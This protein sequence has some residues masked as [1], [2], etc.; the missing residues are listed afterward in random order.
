MKFKLQNCHYWI[1]LFWSLVAL[2]AATAANQDDYDVYY[3]HLDITIDPIA[4]T[5]NG[6]VT[7]CATSLVDNLAL[8][9]L[10]LYDNMKVTAVTGNVVGFSHHDH[11]LVLQLDR[12]YQRQQSLAVTV[13]YSGHP[14][15]GTR[16][17]PM[18]FDRS[19]GVVTISSESCPFYA[20]C[21]WPCKDRPDD[22]PDSMDVKITVPATLTAASNGW[23]VEIIDNKNG[24]KTHHWQIRNPIATYLVAFTVTN[25]RVMTDRYIGA[26]GD[27]LPIRHFVYPEHYN[28]ALVD[29]DNVNTMLQVM[30]SYY[31]KYPYYN[32]KYGIAEYIGYWGGMEYQSLTTVQPY[33]ITGDHT[34]DAVYVHE[35]AHQWWGDCITP[36]DFHHT[37]ISEGFATF[38]EALYFGHLEGPARYHQYMN[39]NNN[40]LETKGILY[41]HNVTNP[42]SVYAQIV[43]NKGAWVIHML[44]HV[45][46]EDKFWAGLRAYRSEFEYKSATTE[47]LQHVF[48][49]VVGDSLGW[50]FRQWIYQ[51]NYP[52]YAF[53][54]RQEQL[55]EHQYRLIAFIDQIQPDAPLFTMPL[56]FTLRTVAKESTF[57]EIVRDSTTTFEWMLPEPATDLQ[58]DKDGWVLKKIVQITTPQPEYVSH[59]LLDATGHGLEMAEPGA[60]VQLLLQIRNRGLLAKQI[61]AELLTKDADIQ[62]RSSRIEFGPLDHG[63]MSSP[64]PPPPPLSFSVSPTAAAHLA[65]FQVRFTANSGYQAIDS[66]LVK[67]GN[68]N[69]LLVDDDHGASYEQYFYQ[70]LTLAR[71]YF[72]RWDTESQGC[73]TA[74]GVLQRYQ[75]VIWF[76]G[77]DRS[78]SLTAEEQQAI[79][80]YLAGGGRLLLTGQDIGVDLMGDGSAQDSAFYQQVLHADF[81]S[82]T[83]AT[84]MMMGISGDPIAGG[85]FVY[86][87]AR[88]GGARNQ[89]SP[90][91]IAPRDGAALILKYL[92]QMSGAGIR[93]EDPATGAR[94][95]YLAFGME[96]ISGPHSDTAKKL[97]DRILSWLAGPTVVYSHPLPAVPQEY[98]L[99]QNFP[100]PFNAV[101]RI[102]Y[103]LPQTDRVTV[104]IYNLSGQKLKT[105]VN[106][107]QVAGVY[108]LLWDGTDDRNMPVATGIYIC[109]LTGR[110][111]AYSKKIALIK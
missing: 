13:H 60:T 33:L 76:T 49:K 10:D 8:I 94:L 54:Y 34:Y 37:W 84:T 42:D 89:L 90:S 11:L 1:I 111:V 80:A 91:A 50:F 17:N 51:P 2:P 81:I 4:E 82:D 29:F 19:R 61:Q 86:I 9:T 38:S 68:P 63:Q 58:I 104:N 98:E 75:Q 93:Y 32:E 55:A 3:Y 102:K 99:W 43:Y 101:T 26:I 74:A 23:L 83:V 35:L 39:E 20:R 7:V 100:N 41:R 87:D 12:I 14:S 78:S 108:E 72:D 105:L 5:I 46:G 45:I 71:T 64:S 52:E 65:T 107:K 28:K 31:G 73:P 21:W 18:T 70:P 95:V 16:F 92:P 79:A 44:R 53:G 85:M 27:T 15:A 47:D 57:C 40:A 103:Y 24:T 36:K 88:T 59:R 67:I 30:E 109:R 62:L 69:L 110:S 97:L 25:Y 56:D 77:D 106:Q 96:G 48:E 6:A 22:K 66:F